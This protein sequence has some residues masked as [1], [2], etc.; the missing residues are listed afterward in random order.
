MD[1]PLLLPMSASV[2]GST[3]VIL[4]RPYLMSSGGFFY[5]FPGAALLALAPWAARRL[6]WYWLTPLVMLGTWNKESF[7]F[8]IVVLYPIL[9][10]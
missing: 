5:D 2:F 3:V 8:S 9:R 7:L 10:Q 4:S 1:S 6:E